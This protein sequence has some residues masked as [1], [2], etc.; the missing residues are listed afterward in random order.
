M[1]APHEREA[2]DVPRDHSL[3]VENGPIG[4][5]EASR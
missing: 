2:S 1:T 4:R 5:P 3:V